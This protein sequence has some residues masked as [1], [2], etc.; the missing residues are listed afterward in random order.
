LRTVVII[1][2][3]CPRHLLALRSSYFSLDVIAPAQ[4]E[5]WHGGCSCF[6]SVM[7]ASRRIK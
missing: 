6:R 1:A 4:T 2:D 5:W 3:G 7:D